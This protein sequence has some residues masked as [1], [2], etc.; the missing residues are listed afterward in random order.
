MSDAP[1]KIWLRKDRY[2]IDYEPNDGIPYTRVHPFSAKDAEDVERVREAT[3]T[4]QVTT[5]T[6]TIAQT[7]DLRALLRLV[8][9]EDS[10]L[11][12]PAPE[13]DD[14][15]DMLFDWLQERGHHFPEGADAAT[16]RTLLD[17]HER[18]TTP[19]PR[20]LTTT[21]TAALQRLQRQVAANRD[22]EGIEGVT[23]CS[24]VI[25]YTDAAEIILALAKGGLS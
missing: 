15:A 1:E 23:P 18:E 24:T 5:G 16:L 19:A 17:D 22:A 4:G 13:P 10:A 14:I 3:V 2:G 25:L 21:Q 12:T 8:E 20:L 6:T 11:P 7:A 9:G